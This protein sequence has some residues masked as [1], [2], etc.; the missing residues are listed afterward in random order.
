[1]G[2]QIKKVTSKILIFHL[3]IL[4]MLIKWKIWRS[5]LI[6]SKNTKLR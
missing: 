5:F 1:L 2:S 3:V 4:A 6:L